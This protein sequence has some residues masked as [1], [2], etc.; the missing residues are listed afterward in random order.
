MVRSIL[1]G[2]ALGAVHWTEVHD[3]T[4]VEGDF[5][6]EERYMLQQATCLY[7]CISLIGLK[8]KGMIQC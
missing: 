2:V 1:D 7:R 4:K 8:P 5:N 3:P 6:L